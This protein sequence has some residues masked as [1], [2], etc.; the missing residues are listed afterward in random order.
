MALDRWDPFREM[1]TLREAMECLIQQSVV[2]PGG[3]L[4]G[5][6][7]EDMPVDV[8][9]M[10]DAFEVRASLPGVNPSDL[11][12]TVQGDTVTIRGEARAEEDRPNETWLI[13]EHRSGSFQRS[14][15]LPSTV[16]SDRAEAHCDNGIL[17]I[18]LPKAERAR[19]RQI[20][21]GAGSATSG[22]G[23]RPVPNGAQALAPQPLGDDVVQKASEESFPA[24]D[25]PSWTPEKI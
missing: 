1:V 11:D 4:A 25:A 18:R 8:K 5:L 10:P 16:D 13:R 17:V 20:P 2:R 12:V 3:L 14:I 9:E 22:G 6:R 23:S 19:A 24:S 21:V 7:G 15:T